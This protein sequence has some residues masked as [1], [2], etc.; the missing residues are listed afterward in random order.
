MITCEQTAWS[1][2]VC[3][4][5][6]GRVRDGGRIAADEPSRPQ[7]AVEAERRLHPGGQ[8]IDAQLL[9]RLRR[10]AR[11]DQISQDARGDINKEF[12]GD[13]AQGFA[14]HPLRGDLAAE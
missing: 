4:A 10:A 11:S 7:L 14:D 13:A 6:R 5:R 8:R 1:S 12:L 9:V 3:P 2:P